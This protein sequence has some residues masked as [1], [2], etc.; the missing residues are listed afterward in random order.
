MTAQTWISV[1]LAVIA[2]VA[3]FFTGLSA[4]SAR[5]QT[6]IQDKLRKDAAQPYVWV[7]L[8]PDEAQGG[9]LLL[10]VGNSGATVATDVRV[11][12]T[13]DLIDQSTHRSN[14]S[15]ADR[16]SSGIASLPPGARADLVIG[17]RSCP[18]APRSPSVAL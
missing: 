6:K 9:L 18:Y 13:P 15:V 3:L 16:I 7:D 8:R 12:F 2:G 1:A 11:R 17:G 10:L 5:Q 4:I 14:Q